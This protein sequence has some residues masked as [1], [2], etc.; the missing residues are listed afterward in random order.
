MKTMKDEQE[1]VSLEHQIVEACAQEVEE[2][3]DDT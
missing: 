3:L 2:S 1:L